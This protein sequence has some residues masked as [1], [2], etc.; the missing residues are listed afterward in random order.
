LRSGLLSQMAST[1]PPRTS[2][3]RPIP[4]RTTE[5]YCA[6]LFTTRFSRSSISSLVASSHVLSRTDMVSNL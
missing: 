3:V 4:V 6:L 1:S 5:Q 2:F